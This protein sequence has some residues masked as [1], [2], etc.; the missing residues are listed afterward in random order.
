MI[1]IILDN[2]GVFFFS[3]LVTHNVKSSRHYVLSV[4]MAILFLFQ[5]EMAVFLKVLRFFLIIIIIVWVK[6]PIGQQNSWMAK[7][8]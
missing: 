6:N 2:Y 8:L 7:V 4:D 1:K 5:V 3:K